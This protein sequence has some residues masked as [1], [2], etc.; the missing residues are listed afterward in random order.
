M[1]SQRIEKTLQEH[2]SDIHLLEIN[3]ESHN[4]SG[5]AGQESHFKVL[6]VSESFAGLSRVA[7]QRKIN[8]L[9][10]SEFDQGLHALT[11]RLLTKAEFEK[12]QTQFQSPK[13]QSS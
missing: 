4:H 1:R 12:Q 11:M 9:L 6:L 7:R 2:F 10:G 8:E 3:D 13:C 5:R